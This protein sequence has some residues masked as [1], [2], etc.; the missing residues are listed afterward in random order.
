[1]IIVKFF[2]TFPIIC[3]VLDKTNAG[4]THKH[5][6]NQGSR[7]RTE[8][9]GY[10]P[11]DAHHHE[12]GEHHSEFDHEAI[13]GSV[14]E[15]EEYDSLS[16]E[17]SKRRLAI[18]VTKMDLN[19]DLYVDRHELKAWILRSFK[20]LSEEEAAERFEE[21][22]EN[23]DEKITWQEYLLNVYDIDDEDTSKDPL[24]NPHL[25]EEKKLMA[26][27]KEMF[28]RADRN[29]DGY[30]D[31]DEFV[32]FQSPEEH[33]EMLPLI[34]KQTLRDKDTN[35][36]GQI[37]FQEF[38]GDAAKNHDKEWLI[39]EKEKFDNDFDTNKDGYL[40]DNEII[41]WVVPSNEDVAE[42][43]VDHLFVSAD[44]NH[45]NRLSYQEIIDNYDTFV[46]SE[47]TDYGD[48]LQNIDHFND[49]L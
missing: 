32:R 47:A 23:S 40:R 15:A 31:S 11:R 45:D 33:P 28:E 39:V 20:T 19:H 7:E 16:P 5:V 25:E 29:H 35:S 2:I 9:G 48:H 37:D 27:D 6:V 10:S 12:G 26:D 42:D 8:D 14:K 44:E 30:L 46:G 41:S 18:L 17:E 21:I 22:D 49:E 24:Q 1:M 43:E 3:G 34:L 36:D 38:I 13:L 4:V